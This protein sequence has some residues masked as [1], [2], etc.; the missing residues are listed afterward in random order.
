MSASGYK[1]TSRG[2]LANVRFT[3]ESRH[4]DEQERAGLKKRTLDVRFTPESGRNWVIGSMSAYDPKRTI[5][6]LETHLN[7][8]RF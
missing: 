7:K 2:Q 8:C 4:L 6:T 5:V 3:P 1:R